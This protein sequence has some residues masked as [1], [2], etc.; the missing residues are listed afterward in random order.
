MEV[1]AKAKFIKMSPRKIRLVADIIRGLPVREALEQLRFINKKATLPLLKLLNSG[2]ANATNNYELDK[3]NL[4]IE[5]VRVDEGPVLRRWQPRAHG[6]AT[7]IRKKMSHISLVLRE[8]KASGKA[9]AKKEKLAAPIRLDS[10]AK[11]DSGAKVKEEKS[12]IISPRLEEEK[13]KEIIDLRSEGG[14]KHAKIE[15]GGK[16][17][18]MKK[19][20]RRKSG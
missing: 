20:F 11:E 14:G 10:K 5:E 16:R 8:I 19:I 6:R 18:F 12:R 13:G 15:G 2:I 7:P 1:K 3:D 17:G 9:K 4:F